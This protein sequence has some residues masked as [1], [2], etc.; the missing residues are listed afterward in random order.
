MRVFFQKYWLCIIVL[1]IEACANIVTPS[2][3]AKDVTPP[4]VIRSTPELNSKNFNGRYVRIDFDEFVKVTDAASQLIISPFM[5]EAPELKLRGKYIVMDFKDTLKPNT[6]YSISFGKSIADINEGNVLANYRYVF[7]TGNII[8]SLTLKGVV[9]NASS[10]KTESG[11]FVMLYDNIYDSVPYKETPYYI[12]KSDESGSFSFTNIKKG[13]YKIFAL[14]DANN[15]FLFDQPGEMIAFSDSL[16]TPQ[17]IDTARADSLLKNSSYNL[18][19]FEETPASQKMLK[20]FASKYGKIILIFRKPVE[21]LSIIP[22]ADN[23]TDSWNLQEI[24]KTKDTLILWLK[25]PDVDSVFLKILDNNIII[26]TAEIALIKKGT[27][28]NRGKGEVV[29][30]V[31]VKTCVNN[32]GAFDFYRS[33]TLESSAPVSDY[34]FNKIVFKENKD[35]VK[36]VFTFNDSI[37]RNIKMEYKWKEETTYSLFIPPGTFKDIF[38]TLNDTVK[39]NFKTTSARDYCNIKL[40]MKSSDIKCDF[41]VR[42]DN[43][44]DAIIQEKYS[45]SNETVQFNYVLPGNYKIKIICDSNNNKKWDTGNYLKMIQPEKVFYYP[46]AISAKANWD[47]SL[48]WEIK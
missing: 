38:G 30:N 2:G 26:D 34:D 48:D 40:S 6:T 47:M 3:G 22:L 25:N 11:V 44:N 12:S 39:I 23:M 13:K 46:S 32:N 21:D 18:S 16:V 7:S 14:K 42:L 37:K 1:F 17:P 31:G 20:A 27:Q 43:E 8:D 29:K 10:L 45:L 19:L 33:F 41:I 15:D 28:E 9:K 35:T 4:K 24:N 5:N 36:A